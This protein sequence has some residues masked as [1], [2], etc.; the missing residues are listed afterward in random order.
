VYV[1]ERD[2]QIDRERE[3]ERK[4]ER[5]KGREGEMKNVPWLGSSGY[6]AIPAPNIHISDSHYIITH[7]EIC[8]P[9]SSSTEIKHDMMLSHGNTV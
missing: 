2:R 6:K 5:E 4:G 9:H 8:H 7:M 3:R 1:C